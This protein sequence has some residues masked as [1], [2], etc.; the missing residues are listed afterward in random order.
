MKTLGIVGRGLAGL[1]LAFRGLQAG[2]KVTLLGPK[3]LPESASRAAQGIVCNKGLLIGEQDLFQGKLIGQSQ[4]SKFI[5][6]I[7]KVAHVKI[8]R[9]WN[10]G[11]LEPY[12]DRDDYRQITDR[13]Y[14]Q[15]FTGCFR[16]RH[17]NIFPRQTPK[18]LFLKPPLGFLQYLADGWFDVEFLLDA[19]ENFLQKNGVPIVEDFVLK[20][21]PNAQD[22]GARLLLTHTILDFD[23]TVLANGY[24]MV[25]TIKES[26]LVPLDFYPVSGRILRGKIKSLYPDTVFKKG[27]AS[28]AIYQ[29]YLRCGS[30]SHRSVENH[31]NESQADFQELMNLIQGKFGLALSSNAFEELDLLWGIRVR[32]QDRSPVVGLLPFKGKSCGVYMC[33]G[34]YKNGLQLSD[35]CAQIVISQICNVAPPFPE[36]AQAF[37]ISRFLP[38]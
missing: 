4:L 33:G 13:A 37:N 28:L 5:D 30:T 18:D 9:L 2:F 16:T 31:L 11:V 34:L 21:E 12:F 32:T 23:V 27:A 35:I 6:E 29:S 10:Q 7:E 15:R 25:Q 36:L 1:S 14:H 8:P 22:N 26:P 19:L 20:V 3:Q 38:H 17:T 24:G